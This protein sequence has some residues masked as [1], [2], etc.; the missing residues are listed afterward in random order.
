M[1][2]KRHILLAFFF[3]SAQALPVFS[4]I[5]WKY[6]PPP[7]RRGST[8]CMELIS[9]GRYQ[10]AYELCRQTA[11]ANPASWQGATA[12]LDAAGI[13]GS[14]LENKTL[15]R[16]IRQQVTREY[17]DSIFDVAARRSLAATSVFDPTRNFQAL[18]AEYDKVAIHFGAPSPSLVRTVGPRADLV[19]QTNGLK[20]EIRRGLEFVYAEIYR[21]DIRAHNSVEA[22]NTVL[23]GREAIDPVLKRGNDFLADFRRDLSM[24]KGSSIQD[25][26]A[27]PSVPKVDIISPQPNTTVSTQPAIELRGTVGNYRMAPIS[28]GELTF[29]LDGVDRTYDLLVDSEINES[30]SETGNFETLTWKLSPN[31]APGQH[32][33]IITVPAAATSSD[34][35]EGPAKTIVTWSFNV[36]NSPPPPSTSQQTLQVSKDAL[37]YEKSPHSNEGANPKLTLEKI[38]GKASRDLLGFNLSGINAA[39]VSKATLV[40][41]IDPSDQAAGW[42]NGDTVNVKPVT[43]AWQEGNG[44]SYG[45]SSSQQTAGSGAG[46]TWFSPT[47]DNISNN[48]SNSVTQ[49]SG[50]ATY[51]TAGAAPTLTVQ[52]HQTGELRFNVTADVRAGAVQG[53]LLRKD[54]ENKGSKVTFYSK[55]GAAAAGNPALAPRLIL[56]FGSTTTQAPTKSW[57][58]IVLDLMEQGYLQL[59]AYWAHPAPVLSWLDQAIN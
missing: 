21:A 26:A 29:F 50:G 42:G 57:L 49:W 27:L 3:W 15:A 19:A 36:A 9:R 34:P 24:D 8:P 46:T 20:P 16:E 25:F 4:D 44:K 5:P 43:V 59:Q 12:L 11:A 30:L 52:N 13:A 6:P 53:W 48:S 10:E 55:E 39:T 40:L 38:T 45:L 17:P 56:E 23:F 14:Y 1:I 31:L 18:L 41:T 35:V 47:D 7:V 33:A 28:L 37:V 58:A 22:R 54:A 32:T 2:S 51:A